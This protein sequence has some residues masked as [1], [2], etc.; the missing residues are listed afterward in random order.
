ME[1]LTQQNLRLQRRLADERVPELPGGHE[2]GESNTHEEEDKESRRVTE[3]LQ[4]E[5][6]SQWAEGVANPLPSEDVVNP[7]YEERRLN[8]AIATL[9]EKY[10]EKYNQLQLEIQQKS[11]GKV[12]RVDSLLNMSSPFTEHILAIQLL[13]KFKI[14][15]IQTY[16]GVEDPTEHLDNYKTHMDLQG[17]P[18]ELAC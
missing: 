13:E 5:N 2:E 9:D 7:R 17:T 4:P 8:Q 15:T 11:K 10:E 18:Q 1:A 3:R 6:R 14:P 16:T 12:S